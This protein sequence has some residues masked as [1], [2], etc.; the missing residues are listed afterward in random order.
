MLLKASIVEDRSKSFDLEDREL[1]LG[2]V[3]SF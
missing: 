2:I 3:V 1:A